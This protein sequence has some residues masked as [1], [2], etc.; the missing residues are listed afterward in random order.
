MAVGGWGRWVRRGVRAAAA[1]ALAGLALG[2]LLALGGCAATTV[3]VYAVASQTD[4]AADGSVVSTTTY[5]LDES[6][7]ATESVT[8]TDGETTVDTVAY[9]IYGVPMPEEGTYEIELDDY[10]QPTSIVYYDADGEVVSTQTFTYSEVAGHMTAE[11]YESEGL[12]F[13]TTYD[14]QDG[15]PLTGSVTVDGITVEIEFVYEITEEGG[16]TAQ[17]V[18]VSGEDVAL[19]SY[20]YEEYDGNLEVSRRYNPDG[21]ETAYTYELVEEPSPYAMARALVHP[22]DYEALLSYLGFDEDDA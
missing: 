21:S 10:G 1:C 13:T 7:N 14:S 20:D 6:G 17:H 9:D 12:S 18:T 16:V 19:Y 22:V 2:A 4:Y 5:E 8:T 15:W 11:T 3:D